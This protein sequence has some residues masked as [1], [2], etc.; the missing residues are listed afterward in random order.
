VLGI[1]FLTIYFCRKRSQSL[2]SEPQQSQATQSTAITMSGDSDQPLLLREICFDGSVETKAIPRILDRYL[3]R[4]KV[5]AKFKITTHQVLSGKLKSALNL[6][7]F[8]QKG[9]LNANNLLSILR[10]ISWWINELHGETAQDGKNWSIFH[11]NLSP[12]NIAIFESENRTY[13]IV[14]NYEL[15]QGN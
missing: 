7:E 5:L 11:A 14:V 1:V 12:K 2:V 13:A 9:K 10:D 4:K 6:D 3:S 8:I 15:A